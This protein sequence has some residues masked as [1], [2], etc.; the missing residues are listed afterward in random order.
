VFA[1]EGNL[2]EQRGH[3]VIRYTASNDDVK[4]MSSAHLAVATLWNH[5][6][7]RDLQAVFRRDR[8][9]VAHFHNT[10][11]LLSPAAYRAARDEGVA[12]VQTLHNYRLLCPNALFL[13]AG[14]VCEDCLGKRVPWP[15][16]LHA[17]YRGSRVASAGVAAMVGVHRLVRT[18][19]RDVDV[20]V[21]LTQFAR[22]KFIA[23]GL[24]EGKIR[25]KPNFVCPAAATS[26]GRDGFALFVGRLDEQKGVPTLLEAWASP[27][28]RTRLVLVGDGPLAG[29][30]TEYATQHPSVLWMGRRSPAEVAALMTRAAYVVIPSRS[31]ENFPLVAAEAFSHGAAVVA[32]DLGALAEIVTPGVTGLLFRPGDATHLAGCVEWAAQHPDE[33]TGFGFNARREFE[34]KYTADENYR[35]LLD[36]YD[37]AV[38]ARPGP[39]AGRRP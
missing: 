29:R 32:S 4:Q 19:S 34:T 20:F 38:A 24:P 31:Y 23:G 6:T 8:P 2:L 39:R 35:Q 28:V 13:R 15:G 17:C 37:A 30:V 36:I 26:A 16:V 33:V 27:V 21:A 10:F 5:R 22:G 11:P 18:W 12:V 1:N 3:E 25:V 7:Y 14:K 9:D